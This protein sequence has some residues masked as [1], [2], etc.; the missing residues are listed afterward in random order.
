[1][2]KR[3]LLFIGLILL[4]TDGAFACCALCNS[5]I[6]GI[7]GAYSKPLLPFIVLALLI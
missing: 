2:L 5:G 6:W 1:M 3:I 7:I 4:F